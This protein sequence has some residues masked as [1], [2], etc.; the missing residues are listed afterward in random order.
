MNRTQFRIQKVFCIQRMHNSQSAALPYVHQSV[1]V[2]QHLECWVGI[3]EASIDFEGRGRFSCDIG[4]AIW[5]AQNKIFFLFPCSQLTRL[6]HFSSKWVTCIN[7]ILRCAV[8]PSAACGFQWWLG[9]IIAQ[10]LSNFRFPQPDIDH[11]IAL[12]VAPHTS[13]VFLGNYLNYLDYS[14]L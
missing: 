6:S 2:A 4:L 8:L 11:R 7:T 14:S 10:R 5:L 3:A 12:T 1:E 13:T 9:I